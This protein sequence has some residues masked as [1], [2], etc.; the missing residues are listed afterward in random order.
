MKEQEEAILAITEY[1][2]QY[3]PEALS[4]AERR[5][6][7]AKNNEEH[8]VMRSLTSLIYRLKQQQN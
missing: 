3:L 2:D 8:Q 5:L 7:E 1:L 6:N 4:L